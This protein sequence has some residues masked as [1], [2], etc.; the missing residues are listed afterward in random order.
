MDS[1]K[2]YDKL[3]QIDFR[4]A[5][6]DKH[7]A[8]Y[9]EQLRIHI[10]GTVQNREALNKQEEKF[11]AKLAP[12]EKHINMVEGALKLIGLVSLLCGIIVSIFDIL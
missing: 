9:N 10:E 5:D 8:V 3:E 6:M 4:L 11:S 1:K 2:V 7:L 12:I